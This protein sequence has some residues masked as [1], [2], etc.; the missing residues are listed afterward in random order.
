M[1][2]FFINACLIAVV[3]FIWGLYSGVIALSIVIGF[4]ALEKT[5]FLVWGWIDPSTTDSFWDQKFSKSSVDD[6]SIE[7][8]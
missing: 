3:A 1:S 7:E 2:R 5:L 8:K 6:P 4:L